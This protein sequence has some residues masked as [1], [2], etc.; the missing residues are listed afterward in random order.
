MGGFTNVRANR[1]M[2]P[3]WSSDATKLELQCKQGERIGNGGGGKTRRLGMRLDVGNGV[4]IGD[5][6]YVRTQV[7]SWRRFKR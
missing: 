4:G 6:G 5:E 7:G 1:A 2:Q 3:S